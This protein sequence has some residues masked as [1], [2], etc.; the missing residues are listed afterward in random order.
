MRKHPE[1][2]LTIYDV[3]SLVATALPRAATPRNITSGF[4]CTGICPFNP[5]TFEERDFSPVY[6]TDRPFPSL[7]PCGPT[8]H[9]NKHPLSQNLFE[10]GLLPEYPGGSTREA[11]LESAIPDHPAVCSGKI[12][13]DRTWLIPKDFSKIITKIELC[14]ILILLFLSAD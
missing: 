9:S 12:K 7:V 6:V 8:P 5:D 1:K 4:V 10:G 13:L 2:S 11:C 14:T 3:P